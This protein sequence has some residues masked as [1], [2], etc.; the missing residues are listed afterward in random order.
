MH[1]KSD[2]SKRSALPVHCM[3]DVFS[4]NKRNLLKVCQGFKDA[5]TR[6]FE[7]EWNRSDKSCSSRSPGDRKCEKTGH[8][9]GEGKRNMFVKKSIP[10]ESLKIPDYP[11]PIFWGWGETYTKLFLQE[12]PFLD[13]NHVLQT[14]EPR[15][16]ALSAGAGAWAARSH[17]R[18][19]GGPRCGRPRIC[20]SST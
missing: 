5:G 12:E 10:R 7:F 1:N 14:H 11:K 15:Q 13:Q 6:T 19:Q 4:E 16:T 18:R 8:K 17:G 20:T 2:A 9:S 3:M